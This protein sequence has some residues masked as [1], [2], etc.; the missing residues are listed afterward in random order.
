MAGHG[1]HSAHRLRRDRSTIDAINKG[2]IFRYVSKPREDSDI[3]LTIKHAPERR[4]LE[5][6][7]KGLDQLTRKQDE[8]MMQSKAGCRR[9]IR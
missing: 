9:N 3:T 2:E 8:E 7:N 6:R 5:R 1:A 4:G